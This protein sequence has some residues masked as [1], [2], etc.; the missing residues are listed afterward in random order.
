MS[1][2]DG[3]ARVDKFLL[4]LDARDALL[5][6]VKLILDDPE[7]GLNKGTIQDTEHVP[8]RHLLTPF[9]IQALNDGVRRGLDLDVRHL[10][11]E[12]AAGGDCGVNE[13]EGSECDRRG[14]EG[15]YG[16][17][18]EEQRPRW[19]SVVEGVGIF[20]HLGDWLLFGAHLAGVAIFSCRRRADRLGNRLGRHK[21][22]RPHVVGKPGHQAERR[23][24]IGRYVLDEG[25]AVDLCDDDV[26]LGPGPRA[27]RAFIDDRHLAEQRSCLDLLKHD[28][29]GRAR[30]NDLYDALGE[31]VRVS[32]RFTLAENVLAPGEAPFRHSAAL[33]TSARSC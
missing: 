20:H 19:R 3:F 13:G 17:R 32:A 21:I 27:P 7:I 25:G 15:D 6:A 29:A 28:G 33:V 10:S 24:R 5:D 12:L 2:W 9:H 31:D 4:Q 26:G 22:H 18:T 30:L 1:G 14:D 8:T 11:R 16:Q 23:L